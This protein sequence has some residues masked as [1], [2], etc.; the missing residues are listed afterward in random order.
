MRRREFIMG[1]GGGMVWLNATRAQ[2]STAGQ[3]GYLSGRSLESEEPLLVAFREGL[4]QTGHSEAQIHFRFAEGQ[5][6]RLP[7]FA[8]ELVQSRAAVLIATDRPS[9]V[10][11]KGA[12]KIIPVVFASGVNPIDA[13]LVTSL[14]RPDGNLTG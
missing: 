11:L 9:A 7:A 13:G 6:D 12:T 5:D 4:A 1:L 10:A 14:N 8:A 2:P 3:I